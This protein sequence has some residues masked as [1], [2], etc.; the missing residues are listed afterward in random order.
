V[1]SRLHPD[2]ARRFTKIL[3]ITSCLL[4]LL[5]G[6][7]L[8]GQSYKLPAPVGLIIHAGHRSRGYMA[9]DGRSLVDYKTHRVLITPLIHFE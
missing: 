3:A 9:L 8:D 7:L 5:L 2:A 1:G 4:G 6:L